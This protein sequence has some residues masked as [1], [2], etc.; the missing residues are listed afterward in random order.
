LNLGDYVEENDS[1][2]SFTAVVSCFRKI[3]QAVKDGQLTQKKAKTGRNKTTKFKT[4][5]IT[6]LK[7]K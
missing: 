2:K 6:S 7:T 4:M 1:F 5:W 3:E